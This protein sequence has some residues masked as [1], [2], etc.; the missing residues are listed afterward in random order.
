MLLPLRNYYLVWKQ[1]TSKQLL[2]YRLLGSVLY[3]I[4]LFGT[5]SVSVEMTDSVGQRLLH[6]CNFI[7]ALR[8]EFLR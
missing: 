2:V 5:H 6:G 3:Q 8:L 4:T 1:Y 7:Y